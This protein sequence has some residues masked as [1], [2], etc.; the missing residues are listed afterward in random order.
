MFSVSWGSS[1]IIRESTVQL[2]LAIE[3]LYFLDF[4]LSDLLING[5]LSIE[6]VIIVTVIMID[7]SGELFKD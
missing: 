3:Q 4:R 6:T 1:N 5:I 2:S 7:N